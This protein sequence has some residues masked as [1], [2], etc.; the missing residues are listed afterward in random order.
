M[1]AIKEHPKLKLQVILGASAILD[2]YGNVSEL[3]KKDGF[4]ID[5]EIYFLRV[6]LQ[7]QWRNLQGWDYWSFHQFSIN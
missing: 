4:E 6:K 1:I 7:K 2:R 5:A 3:I